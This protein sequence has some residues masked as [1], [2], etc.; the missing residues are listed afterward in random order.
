VATGDN[1]KIH[2]PKPALDGDDGFGDN[3]ALRR[4]PDDYNAWDVLSRI[5]EQLLPVRKTDNQRR[6]EGLLP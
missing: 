2:F 3:G 4:L 1:T 5:P 6:P